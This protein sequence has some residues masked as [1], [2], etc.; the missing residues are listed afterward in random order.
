MKVLIT[1]ASRKVVLVRSFKREAIV[2][3]TDIDPLSPAIYLA[4]FFYRAPLTNS[5]E[6]P[7]FLLDIVRTEEIDM[8]V[9]TTDDDLSVVASLKDDLLKMGAFPLVSPAEVVSLCNDKWETYRFFKERE[10]PTPE[11]IQIDD[12]KGAK[13]GF[14]LVLK[15]RFG[16]GSR[17]VLYLEKGEVIPEGIGGDYIA[18]RFVEG[19]EFTIDAFVDMAGRVISVVPRERITISEGV[20][21]R[22]RTV[23]SPE[24]IE[25]GRRICDA[26]GPLGPVNIQCIWGEEGIF[27]TEI[28]PRFSGGIALTI[29]S[30]ADFVRWSIALAKG[31]TI[32]P[33]SDFEELYMS[34]YNEP[35]FFKKPRGGNTL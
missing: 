22:G 3:V 10:I 18:Q 4:D 1:S 25:W 11:T 20:S 24:L 32:S 9:P 26:L 5:S 14:K 34:C 19:R 31:E 35:V 2:Y 28:N 21:V 33:F 6:F 15:K 7:S 27:F 17:G 23:K 13:I 8:V 16:R 30:G 12:L 29:A